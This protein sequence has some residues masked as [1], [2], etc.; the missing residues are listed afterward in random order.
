MAEKRKPFHQEVAENLIEQLKQGTAP[1]QRPW[2]PGEPG[3]GM[4]MNPTTGKRYKGINTLQLLSHGYSDQRWMTYNQAEAAGAQVRKGSKSTSIQYWKF[5]EERTQT[6]AQGKPVLDGAGQPVKIDVKLERPK[7]FYASVFNAEQ[8]DGLP[9]LQQKEQKERTWDAVERA[10]GILRASGAIINHYDETNR[11]GDR[12]F[13]RPATDTIQLPA[14]SQF[15]S[16]GNYYATA[17]HELGHWTGHASRLN[18][19]L[20]HPF[21]SDGYAKEEL[22]AEIS[23]MILGDELGIG[24]DPGQHVAYVASWIKVLQDDP[25]EIFRAAAEAEKIQEFIHGLEQKQ[26]L[27]N[28]LT[29]DI[30]PHQEDKTMA[31][32]Y[33]DGLSFKG[34]YATRADALALGAQY[35]KEKMLWFIP[36]DV[37]PSLFSRWG[38]KGSPPIVLTDEQ[39]QAQSTRMKQLTLAAWNLERSANARASSQEKI[40]LNIPFKEK[41]EA[42]ALGARWDRQKQS[43]FIP[44]GN[45]PALF[46][47]W[48]RNASVEQSQS[49]AATPSSSSIPVD[50]RQYLVVSFE[51]RQAAKAAGALWDKSV[52]SWYIG[53]SADKDKLQNWLPENVDQ[54]QDPAMPPKWEFADVLR[55]HGC[56]FDG[57]IAMYEHPIMD[58]QKHRI[59]VEGDKGSEQSGFYVGHL[60]G[61]PAGYVKNNRTGVETKWKSK[62]YTITAKQRDALL[63]EASL[64]QA[65]KNAERESN[66]KAVSEW[67]TEKLETLVPATAQVPYLVKKGIPP[68]RGVYT[69]QDGSKLYI[70]AMDVQGKAWTMQYISDDGSK[71]FVKNGRKNGCFHPVGGLSAIAK[72]PA[73]VIAEGYATAVS[74]SVALG[75]GTVAAFD[76]GNLGSVAALLTHKFPDKPLIIAGDD[77]KHLEKTEHGNRGVIAAMTTA[78]RLGGKA[79]FPI[80][81]P[82]E[83]DGDPKR[84]TDFNDLHTRSVLGLEAVTRQVGAIV[85]R[86][87]KLQSNQVV[88]SRD[89]EVEVPWNKLPDEVRQIKEDAILDGRTVS[90]PK[91][92]PAFLRAMDEEIRVHQDGLMKIQEVTG[93]SPHHDRLKKRGRS[94]SKSNGIKH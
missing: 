68:S 33:I 3:A 63:E 47:K 71:Q 32:Q 49:A 55:A 24:H 66:H 43:W 1:W 64:K 91:D 92:A 82:G 27:T 34:T 45:D 39:A 67:V 8:I 89:T 37:D 26:T 85:A 46:T 14:Q 51:E 19:D 16:A 88:N 70:P 7:V 23:S 87:T 79:V 12:A 20:G 2:A 52:K 30:A 28:Q 62:G 60:D 53:P 59:A 38:D 86:E 76:A 77:D 21:G 5:T 94:T 22:R 35:D 13:Y 41:D 17:L 40:Y 74:L 78:A 18:R 56:V 83:Q 10:D 90:L 9:P 84:Y 58:G 11:H 93:N 72:A 75:Y 29:Q 31:R 25:L 57:G 15:A 36:A 80:F 50:E 4:P 65:A 61:H 44:T 73:I 42:R 69:D 54:Q 6:D 48:E 81:A